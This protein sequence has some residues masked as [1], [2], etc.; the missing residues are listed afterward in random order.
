MSIGKSKQE[1]S[2]E[3]LMQTMRTLSQKQ[4]ECSE[5]E[6]NNR[7][8]T[9]EM[10]A[11]EM[12]DTIKE[13][14]VEIP[15]NINHFIDDPMFTY[16]DFSR[17]G[18]ENVPSTFRVQD[19]SWDDHGFSL[20]NRLYNDVGHLLDL[21]FRA[22][23]NLT[24]FTMADKTN[25]DTSKFRRAIWNYIQCIYGIRHDDYDYGEVNQVN[26][27]IMIMPLGCPVLY[28]LLF[29]CIIAF[30]AIVKNVHKNGMLFP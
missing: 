22:A 30:G 27:I 20:I 11:H 25:V 13:P 26:Q 4:D 14:V 8:K 9:V 5:I 7:F 2:V 17:R 15:Q 3:A 16:Q 24:Y 12:P 19:Y 10:Q 28:V 1:V 29:I 21:K 23:Y 6:L 18:A